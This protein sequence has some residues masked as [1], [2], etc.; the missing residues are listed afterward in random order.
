[1]AFYQFRALV[2]PRYNHFDWSGYGYGDTTSF[3]ISSLIATEIEAVDTTIGLTSAAAFP[4]AG[5]FFVGGSWGMAFEY[6]RYTGKS[7]NNLTGCTREPVGVSNH[8]G[9][10][11]A[12]EVAYFWYPIQDDDGVL[13]FSLNDDPTL[14][15]Q[16]WEAS[17]RGYRA[18]HWAL[19]N[20]HLIAIQTRTSPAGAWALELLGVIDSPAFHDDSNRYG[21]W[22]MKIRHVGSVWENERVKGV[23][24]GNF[25]IAKHASATGST[26][27]VLASDER[28]AG[29]YTQAE[30]D[31]D[32]EK[33]VDDD[34]GTLWIAERFMGTQEGYLY[35]NA[36]PEN[37]AGAKF[38]QLYLNP[39][40]DT[41]ARARWIE[42]IAMT[43]D[44]VADISLYSAN[45]TESVI[46]DISSAG[47]TT[48][49]RLIICED[50][51]I[52]SE[53]NPIGTPAATIENSS[54]FDH[55]LASGGD[56][57]LRSSLSWLSRVAWGDGHHSTNGANFPH[58][59]APT[60]QY[61]SGTLIDAP[62]KGETLRYIH[63]TTGTT[64]ATDFWNV[65]RVHN[66]GYRIDTTPDQWVAVN[67]PG[68]GLFLKADITSTDPGDGEYLEIVDAA[69]NGSTAG[70]AGSG[71][72]YIGGEYISYQSKDED[73]VWLTS[74]G[75]RGYTGG[76]SAA[77][78]DEGDPVY[79]V[80][81]GII[82]DAPMLASVA[83]YRYG[84]TSYPAYF[85]V[86]RS[87]I[88]NP[89]TSADTGWQADYT[90]IEDVDAASAASWVEIFGSPTRIQTLLIEFEKMTQDP[91]R[92]RVNE[93]SAILEP[94]YYL[95]AYWL[96]NPVATHVLIEQIL[97]DAGWPAG[98][99]S[100]NGSTPS[101]SDVET[102]EDSAWTVAVDLAE[103]AGVRLTVDRV[104]HCSI[105]ADTFWTSSSP[106]YT[107]TWDKSN[108]TD[109]QK[110]DRNDLK[111]A[112]VALSWRS[113]DGTSSGVEYYPATP[114]IA[115]E[116]LEIKEQVYSSS[117]AAQ[118]AAIKK[119]YLA[120]FPYT[121]VIEAADSQ[122]T[123]TPGYIH[124]LLWSF[125]LADGE[126]ERLYMVVG[127]DHWIEDA[128]WHTTVYLQ[129][130]QRVVGY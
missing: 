93:I 84:G 4:S 30:P 111:V 34:E 105:A 60:G 66:A 126:I 69:G 29:D 79:T 77:I 63:D 28:N 35:V 6:V 14:S 17:L 85:T 47:I 127:V 87:N 71:I 108:V 41:P 74:S 1:M 44:G 112:Q 96:D 81:S 13:R 121:V 118:A 2:G 59:D 67:F 109:I 107:F 16:T 120:H 58:E 129:Q 125:N 55:L 45:G 50:L 23:R 103:F 61:G 52:F 72:I 124:R 97:V 62:A 89:R 76:T 9:Y 19:R 33:T 22:A 20:N 38:S 91:G 128:Q 5:G 15:S 54:F 94:T 53:L 98:A 57:W 117:S 11:E 49:E 75:A 42:I 104:S 78:H 68:L 123:M 10:H 130:I 65:G 92:P 95:S 70:I 37:D 27:L 110:S 113:P 119:Y 73:G 80:E 102:G 115:G 56:M 48:H 99:V 24:V 26:S 83:W 51:A 122:P 25:D 116:T 40:D 82:T 46:L 106:T 8:A 31:F 90:T 18:R 88:L 12:D 39:P 101:L 114:G 36:D 3:D 86:F 21:Q 32:A 43:S 7:V 100:N 64:E